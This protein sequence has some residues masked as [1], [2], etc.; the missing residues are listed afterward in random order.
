VVFTNQPDGI[1]FSYER[2]L[3]NKFREA[4]GFHGTPLKLL[5]RGREKAKK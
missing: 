2:Y 4:F 5:F 3:T 1:H